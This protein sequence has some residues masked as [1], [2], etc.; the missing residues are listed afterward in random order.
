MT[1]DLD[2][3]GPL[4]AEVKEIADDV[5]GTYKKGKDIVYCKWF[6]KWIMYIIKSIPERLFKRL[7]L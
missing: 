3:P 5:Y 7:S 6:W 2:L 4:T 1:E